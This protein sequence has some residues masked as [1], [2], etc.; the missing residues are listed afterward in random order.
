[1]S[2]HQ[3]QYELVHQLRAENLRGTAE[4]CHILIFDY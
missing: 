1:M 3:I 2:G 4:T